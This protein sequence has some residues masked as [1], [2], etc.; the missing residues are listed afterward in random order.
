MLFCELRCWHLILLLRWVYLFDC[1]VDLILSLRLWCFKLVG[2]DFDWFGFDLACIWFSSMFLYGG[3]VWLLRVCW[4]FVCD[5][6]Y[7]VLICFITSFGL[8][9]LIVFCL[10]WLLLDLTLLIDFGFGGFTLCV[11][12][13]I[14]CV[15]LERSGCIWFVATVWVWLL[16]ACDFGLVFN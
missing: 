16:C 9:R 11:W 15:G 10:C 3:W 6:L 2:S 7:L 1:Y 8:R 14:C 12:V 13:L 5:W 4:W